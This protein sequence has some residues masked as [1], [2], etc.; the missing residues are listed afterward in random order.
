MPTPPIVRE[1]Y[2]SSVSKAQLEEHY[3]GGSEKASDVVI[4][5]KFGYLSEVRACFDRGEDGSRVGERMDCPEAVSREG[6]CDDDIKIASFDSQK[7]M[8][9]TE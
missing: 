2:G 3:N 4:I 7:A 6:S 9:A 1:N 8:T 5:C